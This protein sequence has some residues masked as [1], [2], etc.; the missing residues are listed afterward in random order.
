MDPAEAD[1][2]RA[3]L[4][5]IAD[6]L[7]PPGGNEIAGRQRRVRVTIGIVEAYGIVLNPGDHHI[8]VRPDRGP[9]ARVV[10]KQPELQRASQQRAA[11]PGL[12]QQRRGVGVRS[13]G[14]ACAGPAEQVDR[15]VQTDAGIPPERVEERRPPPDELH[16]ERGTRQY[17]D[18]RRAGSSRTKHHGQAV[19]IAVRPGAD[20]PHYHAGHHDVIS[21]HISTSLAPAAQIRQPHRRRRATSTMPGPAATQ[22]QTTEG[23]ST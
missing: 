12:P 1:P 4:S 18:H 8:M 22:R 13:G 11:L 10:Q 19:G 9:G 3:R 6:R 2:C 20:I 21:R 17:L 7:G 23:P 16:A 14:C 5:G 15:R